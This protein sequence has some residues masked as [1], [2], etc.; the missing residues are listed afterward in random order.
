MAQHTREGLTTAPPRQIT[1]SSA[2]ERLYLPTH[3]PYRSPESSPASSASSSTSIRCVVPSW[4]ELHASSSPPRSSVVALAQDALQHTTIDCCEASTDVGGSTRRPPAFFAVGD[5]ILDLD[6]HWLLTGCTRR[7]A[8]KRKHTQDPAKH[9]VNNDATC[10]AEQ[11]MQRTILL[12][13][14][15]RA[16]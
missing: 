3:A 7:C 6:C 8:G 16:V 9:V 1:R 12:R 15:L 11:A 5:R 2:H 4:S 10:N 14:K 13:C